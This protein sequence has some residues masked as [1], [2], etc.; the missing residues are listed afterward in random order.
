MRHQI[1]EYKGFLI[2]TSDA[3]KDGRRVLYVA[4]QA[5]PEDV[6]ATKPRR[7]DDAEFLEIARWAIDDLLKRGTR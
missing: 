1:G 7:C 5:A 6:L 2:Q 4:K 3:L